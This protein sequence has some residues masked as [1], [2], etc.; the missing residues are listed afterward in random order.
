MARMLWRS[1]KLFEHTSNALFE[2]TALIACYLVSITLAYQLFQ[3]FY[4]PTPFYNSVGYV[5]A[6]VSVG[7]GLY[8]SIPD[9]LDSYYKVS[10]LPW[11]ILEFTASSHSPP[12][13]RSILSRSFSPLL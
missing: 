3:Y 13:R 7:Y 8:Y 11:N 1:K 9:F 10:R 12:R 4:N 5:D 2:K 6:Y